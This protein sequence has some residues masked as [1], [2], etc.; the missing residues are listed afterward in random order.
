MMS[1]VSLGGEMMKRNF[2]FDSVE[3]IVLV[4][5]IT[6]LVCFLVTSSILI[7]EMTGAARGCQLRWYFERVLSKTSETRIEWD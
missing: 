3:T 7:H 4:I 1:I 6:A 2:K 5:M